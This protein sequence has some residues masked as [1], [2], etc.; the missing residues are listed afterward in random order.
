LFWTKVSLKVITIL[1]IIYPESQTWFSPEVVG[2]I[3]SPR[4]GHSFTRVGSA[5]FIFGGANWETKEDFSDIYFVS[6]QI[7][8]LKELCFRFIIQANQFDLV[9]H[10]SE[11]PSDLVEEFLSQSAVRNFSENSH[12]TPCNN[13][14][15][16]QKEFTK[17]FQYNSGLT[18]T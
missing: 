2:D 13:M 3:P 4:G 11:L 7:M 9:K 18:T 6:R 14:D 10:S 1:L 5:F 12:R 8:S 15:L 16:E 17:S